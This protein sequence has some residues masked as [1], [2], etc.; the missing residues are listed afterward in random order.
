MG[1]LRKFA[2]YW[3][4]A[5]SW[6]LLSASSKFYHSSV[7]LDSTLT[8]QFVRGYHR[9]TVKTGPDI[10]MYPPKPYAS[11]QPVQKCLQDN[12]I[13]RVCWE[14]GGLQSW[15][16]KSRLLIIVKKRHSRYT[17]TL[18]TVHVVHLMRKFYFKKYYTLCLQ[19]S[20]WTSFYCT[21]QGVIF[22]V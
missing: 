7:C 4:V 22:K 8:F 6:L 19:C 2:N 15:T 16:T 14:R 13:W 1:L 18:F 11:I 12:I 5:G 21:T 3:V 20:V 9:S 17:C 10:A